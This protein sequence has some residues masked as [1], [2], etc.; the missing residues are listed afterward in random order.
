MSRSNYLYLI[1]VSL[2]IEMAIIAALALQCGRVESNDIIAPLVLWEDNV[3]KVRWSQKSNK[4]RLRLFLASPYKTRYKNVCW[5]PLV[6]VWSQK[7]A[8]YSNDDKRCNSA[9]NH[10]RQSLVHG[11]KFVFVVSFHTVLSKS[12]PI[13]GHA[14]RDRWMSTIRM[15]DWEHINNAWCNQ[16]QYTFVFFLY[17]SPFPFRVQKVKAKAHF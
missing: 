6:G 10:F 8:A 3:A 13:C 7:C 1:L 17:F 16:R 14:M 12:P 5:R 15:T 9:M 4:S 11:W 2:L